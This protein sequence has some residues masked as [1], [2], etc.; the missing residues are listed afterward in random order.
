MTLY[1]QADIAKE[2]DGRVRIED[3]QRGGQLL[4]WFLSFGS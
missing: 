3:E 2:A 1:S 4:H